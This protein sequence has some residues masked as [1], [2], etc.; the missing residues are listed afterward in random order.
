MRT[1]RKHSELECF[2]L[3]LVWQLGPCSP[4][5]V[6]RHMQ[7]SPST[8]WSGS[9]GAIYPLMQRLQRRGL[10]VAKSERNGKRRRKEYTVTSKG[11][12]ALK[13]WIGPPLSPEAVTVSYDPLR[14]RARFLGVMTPAQ[15]REWVEAAAAALQEVSRRVE[16]WR[17]TYATGDDPFT[18]AVNRHGE[19]D[20]QWRQAWL[21]EVQNSLT[22]I[23]K[24]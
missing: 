10:L 13:E 14:S 24:E 9:A 1:P 7:Q 23:H 21:D 16:S 19:L 12:A 8:Q 22:S 15:R 4:Y 17:Q 6:R 5:D 2:T 18:A 11:I 3:G 20:V